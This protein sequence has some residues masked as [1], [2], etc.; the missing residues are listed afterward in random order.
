MRACI[1]EIYLQRNVSNVQEYLP[2]RPSKHERK[3]NN[4]NEN[5]RLSDVRCDTHAHTNIQRRDWDLET[6][7]E[8]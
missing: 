7:N 5:K 6:I 2:M 1:C 4:A 8:G 3:D